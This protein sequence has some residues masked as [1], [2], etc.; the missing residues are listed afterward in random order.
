MII[1]LKTAPTALP[2][3]WDSE[4]KGHLRL[5]TDDEKKRANKILIPAA[6]DWVEALTNRQLITATWE[7]KMNCFPRDGGPIVLPK[8][9]LQEVVGVTYI[10]TAGAEQTW[11][12][13]N[14]VVTKPAGDY[15]LPGR[16]DLAY[17]RSY[18][19]TRS[20][21]HAVTV[22]LK[23]GYGDSYESVPGGLS[24]AML[25][26]VGEQFERRE[27]AIVGAIMAVPVG[28]TRLALPYLVEV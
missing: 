9:P 17:G 22:E 4:V 23:A 19:T 24:A 15:C 21:P 11:D 27:D 13:A 5:D 2:L 6:R 18:P 1:S 7:L 26:L 25:L 12:S 28:A 3:D 20:Q 10:D 8:P 16:I 14:Y